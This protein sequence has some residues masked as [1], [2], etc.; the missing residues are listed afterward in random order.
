MRHK[1]AVL[2]PAY[3]EADNITNVLRDIHQLK[4]ARKDCHILPIVVNDGSTDQ[5][6]AVLSQVARQYGAYAIHLPLNLGIGRAVQ[7][8][9][10]QALS[11]N[12][13]VAVQ[14]DGDGQHPATQLTNLI[15]PILEGKTDVTVGSRY[16]RGAGGNVSSGLR[17]FG[18]LF[19][20][21][22]LKLLVG[23]EVLDTTSGFRAFNREALEYLARCYPDDYPEVEAYVLLARQRFR[24][25][26]I[27]VTMRPRLNGKS[28]ITPVRCVYYM[29]KVV[30]ATLIGMFKPVPLR[31][32]VPVESELG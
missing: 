3:N 24:I 29:I 8:G 32:E 26:E 13:D 5:T 25:T 4:G 21:A 30:F 22:L 19:F 28:S 7:T 17:Q 20:S 9:L 6:K 31:L 23:V 12:V 27:P 14:L 15:N 1:I 2:I 18:T 10:L 16:L 11:W